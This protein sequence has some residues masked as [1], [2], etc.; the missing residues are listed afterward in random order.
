MQPDTYLDRYLSG[1]YARHN[2]DWGLP[3]SNF[4]ARRIAKILEQNGI[5]P[6]TVCEV[7]CGSGEIL[8]QLSAMMADKTCQFHGYEL[9]PGAEVQFSKRRTK[10]VSL[11]VGDFFRQSA[12]DTFDVLLLMDVIE[13]VEDMFEFLRQL[14]Q[15]STYQVFHIPLDLSAQAILRDRLV[16]IRDQIGHIHYFTKKMALQTLRDLG[17][18]PLD[19]FFTSGAI[20]LRAR[21]WQT[22][23]AKLPR[24][25]LS[26]WDKDLASRLLGGFSLMVLTCG[27]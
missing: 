5:H 2:S 14:R 20:D 22:R 17:Y 27:H 7:G 12:F 19:W 18:T 15:R 6:K 25:A 24:W 4:K 23:A 16:S 8:V 9:Q 1:G 13:H 21:T 10:Q 3:D 11:E 26:R